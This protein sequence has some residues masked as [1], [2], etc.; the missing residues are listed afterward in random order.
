MTITVT[1]RR[2]A[3]VLLAVLA[4]AA[5]YLLGA[6]H[7]GTAVAS[8]AGTTS[9]DL[10]PSSAVAA[11]SVSGY[12]TGTGAAASPTA[13]GITVTGTGKVTGTPDTL[14][15]D[16]GVNVTGAS[17]SSA[18]A[19]ANAATARVQNALVRRGVA[20]RDLQTSGLSIQPSYSNSSS[21]QETVTG[22]QVSEGLSA[23]L[24]DISTAGSTINAAVAAGGN[25]VS[26]DGVGLDLA[27]TSSLM[28]AARQSAF[29]AAKTKAD[30]YAQA[31]GRPL[32]QVLSI[33][34]VVANPTPV[35]PGAYAASTP[36][37]PAATAVP[38]Q[39]GS[40]DVSV[41]VTVVFALG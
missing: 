35:Y 27:D 14:Q 40:Q 17:V 1:P 36:A 39:A 29:S 38:V 37:S 20:A 16:F 31:A 26:I 33:S 25:S 15:V 22:Y 23:L 34:E 3:A 13:G 12:P 8:A 10:A 30:Q 7:G 11:G 32:G 2:V 5:F 21:G 4:F 24:H 19:S 6:S 9:P 18:L 41:T 28:T